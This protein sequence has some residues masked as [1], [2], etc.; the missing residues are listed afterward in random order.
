MSPQAAL[1]ICDDCDEIVEQ[2]HEYWMNLN[3]I[4]RCEVCGGRGTD[5]DEDWGY[6]AYSKEGKPISSYYDILRG[7]PPDELYGIAYLVG[8]KLLCEKCNLAKHLGYSMVH[9]VLEEVVEQLA[10]VNDYGKR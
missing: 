7:I 9:G 3:R 1:A 2:I 8:L 5:I 6:C 4:G 10:K